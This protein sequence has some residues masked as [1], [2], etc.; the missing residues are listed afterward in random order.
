MISVTFQL[1]PAPFGCSR[2]IVGSWISL[3][4]RVRLAGLE[5]TPINV[6]DAYEMERALMRFAAVPNGGLIVTASALARSRRD[7]IAALALRLRLPSGST[8][9]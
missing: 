3:P 2:L 4:P 8:R 7:L 5:V 6:R 9:C 1:G